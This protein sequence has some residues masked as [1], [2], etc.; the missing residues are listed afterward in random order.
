MK[1]NGRQAADLDW[2]DGR[3]QCLTTR[4][5]SVSFNRLNQLNQLRLVRFCDATNISSRWFHSMTSQSPTSPST[6]P[7]DAGAFKWATIRCNLARDN[8]PIQSIC[9]TN[10]KSEPEVNL[11][12]ITRL[13]KNQKTCYRCAHKDEKEA[14][15]EA[16]LPEETS[17]KFEA[18]HDP[19][20]GQ[21]VVK[22]C[23]YQNGVHNVV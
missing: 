10:W 2:P 13:C 15:G 22:C 18:S 11:T 21:P 20:T 23:T 5:S 1:A 16:C 14:G 17:Y 4:A 6:G 12:I 7:M 9:K 3:N 8:P 19:V